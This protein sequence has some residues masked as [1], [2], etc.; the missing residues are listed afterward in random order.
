M[1]VEVG[2][3]TRRRTAPPRFLSR[4]CLAIRGGGS[5]RTGDPCRRRQGIPIPTHGSCAKAARLEQSTA[6]VRWARLLRRREPSKGGP[7]TSRRPSV[8]RF[9]SSTRRSL[10]GSGRD[11]AVRPP[12]RGTEAPLGGFRG[13]ADKKL[14]RPSAR[15]Q[16]SYWSLSSPRRPICGAPMNSWCRLFNAL[17]SVNET[18]K[19]RYPGTR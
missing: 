14:S 2:H 12:S 10:L 13:D 11:R 19:P 17:L 9:S 8:R 1:V 6:S 15:Y 18:M 16:N 4:V 7:R 3:F 5:Q